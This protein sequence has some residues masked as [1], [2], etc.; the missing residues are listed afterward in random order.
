MQ[1]KTWLLGLSLLALPLLS[2]RA[3]SADLEE[4]AG[5]LLGYGFSEPELIVGK[6]PDSLPL[7]V[8]LPTGAR[9]VGAAVRGEDDVE[10]VLDVRDTPE[11]IQA[12]YK[13]K[14]AGFEYKG[15]NQESRGGF[16]F[17]GDVEAPAYASDAL[18]CRPDLS[19][20]VTI[21]R[22][23][24]AIKDVRLSLNS[25]DCEYNALSSLKLPTLKPP[26]GAEPRSLSSGYGGEISSSVKLETTLTPAEVYAHYAAQ[27]MAAGW[28][29]LET[30]T[31]KVGAL[32]VFESKDAGGKAWRLLLLVTPNGS[33][34]VS[35]SL[36]ALEVP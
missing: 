36:R 15:S 33:G 27:L 8:P 26:A 23:D 25:Y 29:S 30:A 20:S 18:Y 4:L 6:L 10:I 13:G 5:R 34:F 7:E 9:I 32:G 21:Y 31:L 12:F 35:A 3:Q 22:L 17:G 11:A 28:T 24:A 19:F 16:T 2:A 1:M 14:L